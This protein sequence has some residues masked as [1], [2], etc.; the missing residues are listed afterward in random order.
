MPPYPDPFRV[1]GYKDAPVLYWTLPGN[2]L[3]TE[4]LVM[5]DW[6]VFWLSVILSRPSH[7]AISGI[8]GFVSITAAGAA[9]I[10]TLFP[11]TNVPH[12]SAY[13]MSC[14]TF[15]ITGK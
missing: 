2:P 9:R 11:G 7:L 15:P 12:L 10:F 1:V 4:V 8:F 13:V 5:T 6:L 14:F 3:P